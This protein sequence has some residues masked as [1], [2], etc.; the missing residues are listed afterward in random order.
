MAA[1]SPM[2]RWLRPG[3]FLALAVASRAGD[4]PALDPVPRPGPPPEVKFEDLQKARDRGIAFL[5]ASQRPDG[6]WGSGRMTKALNITA[7]PPG[8]LNA[9]QSGTTALC[10]EALCHIDP[11]TPEV[12]QA[13]DKAEAWLV[14]FLPKVRRGSEMELYNC[15]SH[16]YGIQAL[17]ALRERHAGD[18][19]KQAE[20]LELVRGQVSMLDRYEFAYGG[21][22]YYDFGLITQ[23]ADGIPTSF[24]TATA[25]IALHQAKEAGVAPTQKVLDRALHSV[26]A[27]RFPDGAYAYSWQHRLRPRNG[28][29]RPAGSLGRAPACNAALRLWQGTDPI[30]DQ[31]IKDWLDRLITRGGWLD[32]ARKRPV[33]HEAFFQNSGYFYYYGQYYGAMCVTMLPESER[34]LYRAHLEAGLL[35]LQEKDGSWWDYPLYDYHQPYG[36][37]YALTALGWL[38]PKLAARPAKAGLPNAP[39]APAPAPPQG[40]PTGAA[41]HP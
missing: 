29:D 34:P 25:L 7:D 16:A 26:L 32:L 20:L 8:S 30:T 19:K 6:A 39:V 14:G 9:F 12:A 40:G 2:G 31:V 33:P 10:I 36:T 23:K 27:Q 18:P 35:A 22:G 24:T 5:L 1:S 4:P 28:I 13:I 17:L 3:A 37:A 15:W 41:A 21:W 11:G 38:E